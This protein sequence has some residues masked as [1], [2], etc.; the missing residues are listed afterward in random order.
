ME[1]RRGLH[2]TQHLYCNGSVFVSVAYTHCSNTRLRYCQK[3]TWTNPNNCLNTYAHHSVSVSLGDVWPLRIETNKFS[4]RLS[5]PDGDFWLVLWSGTSAKFVPMLNRFYFWTAFLSSVSSIG[6]NIKKNDNINVKINSWVITCW[7]WIIG[8][9][10]FI[11]N[12]LQFIN[13]L[14]TKKPFP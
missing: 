6:C 5:K 3:H 10:Y 13:D 2:I 14:R 12:S 8:F 1:F 9:F 4:I 7:Y 11:R